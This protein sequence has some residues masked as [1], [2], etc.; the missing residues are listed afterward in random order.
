MMDLL[1]YCE[2]WSV[3]PGETISFMVSSRA[4]EYRAT[5]HRLLGPDLTEQV[6]S[7]IDGTHPGSAHAIVTGS[8]LAVQETRTLRGDRASSLAA[9]VWP[10]LPGNGPQALF[11]RWDARR[12]AGWALVLDE[13]GRA[14]LWMGDGDRFFQLPVSRPL[15]PRRWCFVASSWDPRSSRAHVFSRPRDSPDE[16]QRR[17]ASW[18]LAPEDVAPFVIGAASGPPALH[19][20]GKI[21]APRVLGDALNPAGLEALAEARVGG[22]ARARVLAAWHLGADPASPWVSDVSGHGNHAQVVNLP[23]RGMTGPTWRGRSLTPAAAPDDYDAVHLHA[24]DLEDASWPMALELRIPDTWPSGIYAAR[25]EAEGA[26]DEVPFFVRPPRGATTAP[27]VFLAPTLSYLAYA[28]EHASWA[29]PIPA[30]PGLDMIL[31]RVRAEDRF[32]ARTPLLSLYEHHGDGS[33]TCYSSRRRPVVN[34]RRDY[35]LPLIAGPH[36]FPADLHLLEWLRRRGQPFDVVC[37]EDLHTE[38]ADLLSGYAVVLTGSHPEYWTE[39]MLDGLERYLADGGRLM[40]LGGNGFYWVTSIDRH[41]AHV[42][43]VRRGHAGTRVWSSEPGEDHHASTGELGGLWR[44]RGRVPQ[45]LCGVGFTAQGF[46]GARPYRVAHE[47]REGHYGWVVD[48]VEEDFGESGE[49]LGAAAGFEVDRA[50]RSLGTPDRA[51]V[52]ATAD[53]FGPGYQGVVEEVGTADSRQGG[54]VNPDVRSDVVIT[55][56]PAG[57]GVF[58]VGSIAWCTSLL[59]D[60]GVSRVTANVLERFLDPA[61]LRDGA[62]GPETAPAGLSEDGAEAGAADRRRGRKPG[63]ESARP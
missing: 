7:P 57:G 36:Q 44:H 61:S 34:L 58:S 21:A 42:I 13:H 40:Y 17:E 31:A 43:E 28:N 30:T 18:T 2:P 38:G 24:D 50:D 12:R 19:F 54:D 11:G 22:A 63:E 56:G 60:G 52:L 32:A 25:L 46:D 1:G 49:V 35:H 16:V 9:W 33:G 10:T 48:G 15:A 8:Y 51:V 47:V 59:V 26:V 20:N 37:D 6:A 23:A 45:A 55:P 53:G 3:A 27:A 29:N 39:A 62:S 4:G 5:T 41:R 14:A